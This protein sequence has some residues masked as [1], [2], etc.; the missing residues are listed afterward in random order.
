MTPPYSGGTKEPYGPEAT[1]AFRPSDIAVT[2]V[3][4]NASQESLTGR[5]GGDRLAVAV[6]IHERADALDGMALA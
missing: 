2:L 5:A 6:G 3:N 4:P 1:P